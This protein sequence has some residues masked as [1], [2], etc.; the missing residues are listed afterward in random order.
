[1]DISIIIPIYKG[2]KHISRIIAMI[3]NMTGATISYDLELIFVNDYPQSPVDADI[4]KRNSR[5]PVTCI[6]NHENMGIHISRIAGF[7]KAQG[8]Y[9]LFLDQDDTLDDSYFASQLHQ[10]ENYDAVICNG[11]WRNGEKIFSE[12]NKMPHCYNFQ[13]YLK[14][15]YPLVSLGQLLV[16]KQAIPQEWI[17]HQMK[18]NGW[19]DHFLWALLM[20]HGINVSGNDQPLYFHEEDGNNASFCWDQMALSG[21]NFSDIFLSLQLMDSN[22]TTLFK[23]IINKKIEKYWKYQTLEQLITQASTTKINGYLKKNN[24]RTVAVYGLGVFGKRFLEILKYTT[25]EVEYGIDQKQDIKISDIEIYELSLNLRYVDAIIV[26]PVACYN[27]IKNKLKNYCDY[28][29]ISIIDV[30]E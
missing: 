14:N 26:T 28:K 15:G 11:Y 16:K 21:K 6:E 25:A 20:A 27:V 4:F 12:S 1:M 23:Q 18:Y 2:R 5:I 3:E 9:I 8:K 7:K 24:I 22:Q 13:E 19:D 17:E 29:V 10:I 30:L